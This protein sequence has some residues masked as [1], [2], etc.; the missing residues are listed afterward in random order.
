MARNI[1]N[2]A[3]ALQVPGLVLEFELLPA[4]TEQPEW[5][6]EITRSCT[7]ISAGSDKSGLKCALRV[8][9]TDIRDQ[10]KHTVLR[11]GPAWEKLLLGAK[12]VKLFDWWNWGMEASDLGAIGLATKEAIYPTHGP[13][14]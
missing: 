10:G 5:G 12:N 1:L 3:V 4:M 9:P 14:R 7:V 11:S 6:A 2:R 8:T 13:R